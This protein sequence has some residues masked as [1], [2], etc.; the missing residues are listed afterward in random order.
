MVVDDEL[1]HI[2]QLERN[3]VD[4]GSG[5]GLSMCSAPL[6]RA[7]ARR[8]W[9]CGA[10]SNCLMAKEMLLRW[11]NT[12]AA[13][14]QGQCRMLGM[15]AG[16]LI[17]HALV[18]RLTY[19]KHID[20]VLS[21]THTAPSHPFH[22]PPTPRTLR[23]RVHLLTCNLQHPGPRCFYTNQELPPSIKRHDLTTIYGYYLSQTV[24]LTHTH[25][26]GRPP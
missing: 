4:A 22:T 2:P 15:S 8:D 13:G 11:S 5:M 21:S 12:T 25:H 14:C 19:S 23:V 1:H 26:G 16:A 9:P 3:D 20:G 17:G 24:F 18:E 6:R 10:T 7:C